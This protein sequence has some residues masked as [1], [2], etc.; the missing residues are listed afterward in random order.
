MKHRLMALWMVLALLLGCSSEP[1]M[2]RQM[3]KE[4]LI[5]A[6][7]QKL[8][9]S[10]EAEKSAVLATTDEESQAL[11]LEAQ[12]SAADINQ[13]RSELR[14]L[15]VADGRH[16]EIEKLDAFDAAWAELERVDERLLA[17]A[18]ANTNLKAAR[19]LSGEGAAALDRFVDELTEIQRTVRDPEMIRTLAGASVAALRSQSV[20]FVHIPSSDDAEMTRLEQRLRELNGEVDH[21]LTSARQSGQAWLDRLATASQAWS[22][23]QR[24]ATE[25]L[26]LSRENSNVISF[27][28]SVHEKRHVTKECLS[29]LS[30]LLAAI[31]VGPQAPR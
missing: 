12:H 26:R 16:L 14:P 1:A 8:L 13:L 22:E 4:R 18:V 7:Q 31:D 20:L 23:Y 17:L 3:R 27:D 9:E 21:S 24:V 2:V 19:L 29:A 5:S 15:I 25:V 10:V 30:G 6:I 11:A 28:L